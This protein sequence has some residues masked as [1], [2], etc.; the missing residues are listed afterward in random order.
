VETDNDQISVVLV[1]ADDI[2]RRG[3]ESIFSLDPR[4]QVAGSFR[5]PSLIN[6]TSERHIIVIDPTG[7]G[8]FEET[9][10]RDALGRAPAARLA[11]FTH[12][13]DPEAVELALDIGVGAYLVKGRITHDEVLRAIELIAC[14]PI[15]LLDERLNDL[16]RARP[17]APRNSA[18]LT[19][20]G[21]LTPSER[22]I[23]Q[24]VSQ[25]MYDSEIG[26]MRGIK[27]G[28]V[29]SHIHSAQRKLGAGQR[30][31]AVLLAIHLGLIGGFV[32]ES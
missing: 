29:Q 9:W 28:T 7:S 2:F 32:A 10:L 4:F 11:V 25:G 21:P 6:Y 15:L 13:F 18:R 24:L 16:L 5:H 20:A 12:C 1:D 3:L 23:L 8:I 31:H 17:Q 22:E 26:K 14:S 19:P 30:V 27:T